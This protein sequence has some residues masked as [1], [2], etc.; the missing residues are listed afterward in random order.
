MNGGPPTALEVHIDSPDFG[1]DAVLGGL[2]RIS[3]GSGAL[4][5]FGFDPGWLS[6]GYSLVIDP[7]LPLIPGDQYP[8]DRP[9]FGIFSDMAP[10]R[11]GRTLMRRREASVARKEERRPRP[12]D[13]WDYL[14]GVSDVSR[15][16]ALRIRA[17]GSQHFLSDAPH[18]I[19]P[20]A[21]LRQLE[22]SAS[23]VEQGEPLSASEEEEEIA[24]LVAPGSSLGGARPKATFQDDDGSLWIAKFPSRSD[25]WDVAAWE[26]TMHQLAAKAGISVPSARLI[27]LSGA[28]RTF[29]AQR[30]DR[31]GSERHLFASA[32]T[33]TSQHDH[34][35]ETSYL[36]IAEAITDYVVP[37]AIGTDLEQLFRRILF[38]VITGHRDDHLR[39]HGF[40]GGPRGWRLSPSFDMNPMPANRLH[41]MALDATDHTPSVDAVMS[42]GRLYRVASSHA[43]SILDEVRAA[44]RPWRSVAKANS[45]P[46]DEIELMANAFMDE[47]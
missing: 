26:Y 4:V 21:R 8:V 27:R 11:W 38:N 5:S 47:S 12:L 10:D 9:L 23:R 28:Q 16:G 20:V 33:L 42:T 45:I 3:G 24:L 40:L 1:G 35:P 22:H 6:Q 30:F 36:D 37:A 14:I 19:P 41:A 31:T 17:P 39:N 15:M 34:E 7:E 2:R 13:E 25:E 46:R 44:V 32:M 29:I 18:P 43:K